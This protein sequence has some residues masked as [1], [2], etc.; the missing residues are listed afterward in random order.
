MF[1]VT[2]HVV[3]TPRHTSFYLACGEPTAPLI[4]FVHGWP[5]LSISWRHQ[6]P[7]F[8][9]LGFRAIAPDMRG[10][11]RSSVHPRHEDYA[12]EHIVGDMVELL[13]SFGQEKAIWVGHDWGSPVVWEMA[14][15]FP[16][17]C[18]GIANLCVPYFP[19]GFTLQALLSL[20]DRTIYPEAEFPTGQWEYQ[21]FY[22]E[23]FDKARTVFEANVRATVKALIRKGDPAGKGKPSRTAFVRRDGGWFGGRPAAPD[24]PLDTDVLTEAELD[25]YVAALTRNGFHGPGSWYMNP[26]ANRA[27]RDKALNDGRL[28]M[29]VL[30]LHGAYDYTCAT[31][32]SHF[33]DP[34]RHS[35]PDLTEVVVRT[36]HWMAQEN[37]V[38]VNA[39]LARWIATKLPPVWPGS[40]DS[41]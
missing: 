6:L 29:P 13:D 10:Y 28:D 34:M 20:I 16:N 23:N 12:L 32:D 22:R 27:Y 3:K 15:H 14:S 35:C 38:A 39:A 31:L 33:A 9:A 40:G 25:T 5:E 8:A 17:R 2:D 30:F 41:K 26:D 4:I 19:K 1:P 36:G 21:Q 37:P 7:C 18:H 24:L 11:G